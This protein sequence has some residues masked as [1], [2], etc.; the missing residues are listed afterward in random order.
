VVLRKLGPY[1]TQPSLHVTAAQLANI[2][3]T[4]RNMVLR[5][6]LDL[7]RDGV[8]GENFEFTSRE[9]EIAGV[10]TQNVTRSTTTPR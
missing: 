2:S 7:E 8:R 5:W 6:A 3:E 10:T 1:A 9:K 4:A